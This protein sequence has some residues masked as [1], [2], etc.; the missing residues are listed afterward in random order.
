MQA[1]K[2]FYHNNVMY[3]KGQKVDI[4]DIS[5]VK[6]LKIKGTIADKVDKPKAKKED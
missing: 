1:V 4:K 2:N 5:E 3:K 6:E